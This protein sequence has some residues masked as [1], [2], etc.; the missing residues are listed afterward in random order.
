MRIIHILNVEPLGDAEL[1]KMLISRTVSY[2]VGKVESNIR[3]KNYSAKD[4]K[5]YLS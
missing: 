5:C 3:E 1:F 2:P 4:L